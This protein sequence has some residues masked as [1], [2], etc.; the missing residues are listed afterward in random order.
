MAGNKLGA[1][2]TPSFDFFIQYDF[3]KPVATT[4]SN[5]KTGTVK[6]RFYLTDFEMLIYGKMVGF[7][8]NGEGIYISEQTL[9]NQLRKD[10][11]KI[12]S[13]IKSLENAGL[14][15]VVKSK[16]KSNH[17]KLLKTPDQLLDMCIEKGVNIPEGILETFGKTAAKAEHP[18]EA[19]KQAPQQA[20]KAEVVQ[21]PTQDTKAPQI[22]AVSDKPRRGRPVKDVTD[23]GW[24][25][26]GESEAKDRMR[27]LWESKYKGLNKRCPIR[28]SKI[29]EDFYTTEEVIRHKGNRDGEIW[30]PEEYWHLTRPVFIFANKLIGMGFEILLDQTYGDYPEILWRNVRKNKKGILEFK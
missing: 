24:I 29:Q 2:F 26:L 3:D 1:P 15:S 14:I 8:F 17:Y 13:A 16:G 25:V 5:K 22:N 6:E 27:S 18:Q 9:A 21:L 30:K 19:P 20:K 28:L 10:R 12:V 4:I 7:H 23:G 11:G